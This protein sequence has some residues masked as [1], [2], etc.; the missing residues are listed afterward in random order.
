MF[1]I[2]YKYLIMPIIFIKVL[3]PLADSPMRKVKGFISKASMSFR[4]PKF[5]IVI[6][7]FIAPIS[8]LIIYDCPI[9]T[10]FRLLSSWT[11][12]DKRLSFCKVTIFFEETT[13]LFWDDA[14]FDCSI[15]LPFI[16]KRRIF[17]PELSVC[18]RM[19]NECSKR[20]QTIHRE[21]FAHIWR[22]RLNKERNY[23]KSKRDNTYT[24][25]SYLCKH[26]YRGYGTHPRS[27]IPWSVQKNEA[28]GN[29]RKLHS[30]KLWDASHRKQ[31]EFG[32]WHDRLHG[33]MGSK[34]TT[35]KVYHG[36][37]EVISSPR[38]A[39]RTSS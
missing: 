39:V 12:K 19:L 21:M 17:A 11:N 38:T 2:L 3:L 20:L 24:S 23:A 18:Q 14:F 29:D 5:R 30:A 34:T 10:I 35:I 22:Q 1:A 37:T 4:G 36:G 28:I 32:Y 26:L 15:F 31:R 25:C 6:Y 7:S 8:N 13:S 9:N 27:V 33:L 16:Q